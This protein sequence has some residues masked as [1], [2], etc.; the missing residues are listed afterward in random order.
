MKAVD[1]MIKIQ[2]DHDRLVIVLHEIYG[3]NDHMRGVC[4]EIAS[5]QFDV[6]CPNL[7]HMEG[8]FPYEKGEEA[9]RHFMDHVGFDC[10]FAQV[11]DL[12]QSEKKRYAQVFL[13]GFSVGAT[14]AWM[15]STEEIDGIVAYYGSRIR[16]FTNLSPTCPALLFFSEEKSFNVRDV[17]LKLN[18]PGAKIQIYGAAH[19]FT[20]PASEHYN[21]T[22]TEQTMGETLAFLNEN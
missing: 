14:I 16:D 2:K 11:K 7:L 19:G 12:I 5:K 18:A 13:L 9:Y 17:T 22:L 4:E 8:A 15:C 20:N 3:V 1:W 10:A 6:I 21:Q